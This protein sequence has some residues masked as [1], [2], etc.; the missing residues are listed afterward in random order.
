[1]ALRKEIAKAVL[2]EPA[3]E[4]LHGIV[5]IRGFQRLGDLMKE[6]VD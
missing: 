3:V 6:S 2:F 4:L 5:P 1:M